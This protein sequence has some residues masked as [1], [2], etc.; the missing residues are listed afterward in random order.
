M[1]VVVVVNILNNHSSHVVYDTRPQAYDTEPLDLE[2]TSWEENTQKIHIS[3][4]CHWY[5]YLNRI[6]SGFP[7][8][9]ELQ[10]FNS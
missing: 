9:V 8:G 6:F 1:H 5:P 2:K 4:Y 10:H 3:F 7:T